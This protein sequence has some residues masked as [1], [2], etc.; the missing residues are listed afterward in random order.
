M[1]QAEI[2]RRANA[3]L[4]MPVDDRPITIYRLEMIAGLYPGDLPKVIKSKKLSE[5]NINRLSRAFELLENNQI[6][7]KNAGSRGS[8]FEIT[9][10]KPPEKVV[11]RLQFTQNGPKI[12]FQAINPLS[13]PV[14]E[15]LEK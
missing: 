3:L 7:E 2:K 15:K 10:A 1:D 14:L 13:F 12:V 11:S 4:A 5:K 9:P 6:P 8:S